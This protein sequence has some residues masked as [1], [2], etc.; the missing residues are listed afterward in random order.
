MTELI[1]TINEI[2]KYGLE[3]DLNTVDKEKLLEKNLVKIYS[4]YFDIEYKFD[5]SDY[6]DN[7]ISQLPNIRQNVISN[8]K[9]FGFYKTILD[10]SDIYSLTDVVVGDAIDDLSEIIKDLV[11]V[12]W[13]TENNSLADGLW[14][15]ELAFYTHTQQHILNLLNFMKHKN[16]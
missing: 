5:E 16:E 14:Y 12:K 7:D 15:F 3:P 4:L 10:V 9:D 13:R 1:L 8:F 2:I 6:E 11:E